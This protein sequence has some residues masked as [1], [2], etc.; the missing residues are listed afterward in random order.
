[1]KK[2]CTQCGKLKDETRFSWKTSKHEQRRPACKTCRVAYQKR[3]VQQTPQNRARRNCRVIRSTKKRKERDPVG[4]RRSRSDAK[5]KVLYGITLKQYEAIL[6]A[7]ENVCAI[8][9]RPETMGIK[10]KLKQMSVDH[11]HRTGKV[12]ALLCSNCNRGVGCMQ[13]SSELL[14]R[15]AAY[16]EYHNG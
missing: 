15:A 9:K 10:G 16:L 14:R 4:Y 8:C 11:D 7:Q 1:M 5:L 12:R 2:R 3:Y 6:L 13:D